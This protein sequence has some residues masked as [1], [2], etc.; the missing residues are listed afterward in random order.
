MHSLLI[1]PKQRDKETKDK[2]APQLYYRLFN[3]MEYT[4]TEFEDQNSN[5]FEYR[6]KHELKNYIKNIKIQKNLFKTN[7]GLSI[8][9]FQKYGTVIRHLLN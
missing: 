6:L 5:D 9:W 8:L 1:P 7:I 4:R 3:D 2:F